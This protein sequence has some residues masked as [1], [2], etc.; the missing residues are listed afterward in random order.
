[1]HWSVRYTGWTGRL[2]A[3]GFRFRNDEWV[4]SYW[5]IGPLKIIKEKRDEHSN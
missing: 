5:Q 2:Y 4:Y 3:S 1:M